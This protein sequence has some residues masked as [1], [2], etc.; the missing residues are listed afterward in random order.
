[1]F[2]AIRL[3]GRLIERMNNSQN[4][5][6]QYKSIYLD[7]IIVTMSIKKYLIFL[8]VLFQ[9]ALFSQT[10]PTQF[11]LFKLSPEYI[12]PGYMGIKNKTNIVTVLHKSS[13]LLSASH[14]HFDTYLE[15]L[16]GNVGISVG[17]SL[18]FKSFT[19][20]A[21]LSYNRIIAY[22]K[23]KLG[24][25]GSLGITSFETRIGFKRFFNLGVGVCYKRERFNAGLSLKNLT[26]Y[27][28]DN[29]YWSISKT[30]YHGIISYNFNPLRWL[31]S[32]I[33]KPVDFLESCSN[34]RYSYNSNQ[35]LFEVQELLYIFDLVVIGAGTQIGT[36]DYVSF[37]VGVTRPFGDLQLV[38][39]NA[40][41]ETYYYSGNVELVLRANF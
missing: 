35:S 31:E 23:A 37:I 26:Y 9:S 12:N 19:N 3:V 8:F 40:V 15:K 24:L 6:E 18:I 38:A 36:I 13:P 39:S 14:V 34:L 27:R 22:E 32:I 5:S 1:M 30:T 11:V 25:G 10:S 33:G 28:M 21:R 41:G 4:Q 7:Y 17:R 20:T 2:S 16:N 29:D